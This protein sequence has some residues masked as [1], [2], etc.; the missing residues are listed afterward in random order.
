MLPCLRHSNFLL[1]F[2][3]ALKRWAKLFRPFRGSRLFGMHRSPAAGLPNTRTTGTD[4]GV[5]RDGRDKHHSVLTVTATQK[6]CRYL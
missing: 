3:P 6:F 1:N 5:F 4:V 2:S